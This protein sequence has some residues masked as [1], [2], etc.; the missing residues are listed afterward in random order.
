MG[1]LPGQ[2][3]YGQLAGGDFRCE[4]IRTE[5][6]SADDGGA[7]SGDGGSTFIRMRRCCLPELAKGSLASGN[8]SLGIKSVVIPEIRF[9]IC[10]DPQ[11]VGTYKIVRGSEGVLLRLSLT[12]GSLSPPHQ[13]DAGQMVIELVE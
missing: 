11:R 3:F 8:H 12:H 9:P 2:T 7:D 6:G 5:G 10:R 4:G 1:I 13:L